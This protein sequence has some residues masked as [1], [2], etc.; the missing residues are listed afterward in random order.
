MDARELVELISDRV[1]AQIQV[2]VLKDTY[3]NGVVRGDQFAIGSLS[4]ESG[5]SLK[6]DINPRSPYFMK[7]QD[8]NG[9]DGVGGIVMPFVKMLQMHILVQ[10][11]ITVTLF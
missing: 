7:G 5:K 2:D 9:A 6:I 11:I 3:P 8:F 4:G 1:P 10:V